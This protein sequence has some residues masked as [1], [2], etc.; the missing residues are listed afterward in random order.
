MATHSSVLAWR[1]PGTGE[2][3]GL[4][5][6]GSHRVGHDWSDLAAVASATWPSGN[7]WCGFSHPL[8]SLLTSL[9]FRGTTLSWFPFHFAGGSLSA[10]FAGSSRHLGEPGAQA[11]HFSCSPSAQ[12]MSSHSPRPSAPS[13]PWW[14]SHVPFIPDASPNSRPLGQSMSY[15]STHNP[16]S[17]TWGSEA[18]DQKPT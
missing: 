11:L 5:S 13:L 4:P 1:I 16:V 10:S 3:G 18:N 9:G 15:P 12:P 8:P 14:I 2:P 17:S 6:M 7:V